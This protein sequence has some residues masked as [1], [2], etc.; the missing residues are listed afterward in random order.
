MTGIGATATFTGVTMARRRVL[1]HLPLA[2]VVLLIAVVAV[3]ANTTGPRVGPIARPT[4]HT[5]VDRDRRPPPSRFDT[6]PPPAGNGHSGEGGASS[7]WPLI[8]FIL[9]MVAIGYGAVMLYLMLSVRDA[10]VF[11]RRRPPPPEPDPVLAEQPSAE[12]V[13]DALRAGLAALIEGDDA[14]AAVIA[15][16]LRL[17]NLAEQTGM[18]RAPS[19][20]P[21][22]LVVRMLDGR[23]TG[24]GARALGELTTVYRAARYSPRPVPESARGTARAALD[25][26][27]AELAVPVPAGGPA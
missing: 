18:P 24:A 22:D 20:A 8:V 1:V 16:W 3:A 19:D 9:A 25:R 2:L 21:G 11:R 5:S 12:Q 14:R 13:Q 15:C 7:S 17:E 27:A 6:P 26:L 23:L 10:I 4:P